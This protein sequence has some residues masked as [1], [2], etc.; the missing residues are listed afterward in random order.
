MTLILGQNRSKSLPYFQG[1]RV[2]FGGIVEGNP[3][4]L[5]IC[6]SISAIILSVCSR[7]MFFTIY[8]FPEASNADRNYAARTAISVFQ[9]LR[10]H[11]LHV[12]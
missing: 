10:P 5:P 4:D 9:A 7:S 12:E 3:T 1:K 2:S 11:I 6:P 8:P